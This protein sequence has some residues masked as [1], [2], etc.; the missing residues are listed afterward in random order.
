[1]EA[2]YIKELLFNQFCVDLAMTKEECQSS[3]NIFKTAE[4]NEDHSRYYVREGNIILYKDRILCRTENEE[5]TAKLR[6]TYEKSDGA[7]FLEIDNLLK[8]NTILKEYG[9]EMTR[10][11]PF[12]I[13]KENNYPSVSDSHLV[14]YDKEEILQFKGDDR[15]EESFAFSEKYPDFAAVSY[16][17]DGEIVAMAGTNYNGKYCS[18]I[19]I[20]VIHPDYHSKGIA[21]LLVKALTHKIFEVTNGEILPTYGTAFSHT[22]SMNVAIHAGYKVGWSEVRIEKI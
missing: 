19:G 21:T 1:M 16:T 8:L 9:Y 13:P 6:E 5:L 7:W 20:E 18:E 3:E 12:F 14:F 17:I 10:V 22:K 11:G 4:K 15:F 2:F